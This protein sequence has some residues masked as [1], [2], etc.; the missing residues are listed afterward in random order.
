M[1]IFLQIVMDAAHLFDKYP[2][3]DVAINEVH[4][5]GKADSPSGT[6]LS[7]GSTILQ[8]MKRKSELLTALHSGPLKPHQLHVSSTRVGAVTG[9]HTVT[10]DSEADSVEVIH[11]AKSRHGMAAGAVA[12]AEWIRGKKGF[13]TMR[14]VILP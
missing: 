11:T 3:Y 1:N 12:A 10:F 2:D 4:H 9:K 7:L 8:T 13:Y 6:A 5:R 14:D